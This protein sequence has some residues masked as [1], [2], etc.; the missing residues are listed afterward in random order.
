MIKKDIELRPHQKNAVDKIVQKN[1]NLL[2]S[3]ATGSGKTV[4]AL[5]GFEKLKEKGKAK[6]ALI[7]TPASLR[8]NFAKQGVEK[9]TTDKYVI[10]GNKIENASPDKRFIDPDKYDKKKNYHIVSYDMFKKD[11]EKYVEASGADTVIYDEIHRAKN[12]GTNVTKVIK[13]VRNQHRNFIG[14]TGSIVSN[15]PADIVPLVDAMTDGKHKLGS[16]ALFESRFL[17]IG[18]QGEKKIKNKKLIKILTAPYI[19]HVEISDLKIA[20][21]P[22]KISKEVSVPMSKHQENL[23][24]FMV[25]QLDPATK[26]KIR[27]GVGKKLKDREMAGIFSKLMATRKL[28]NYVQSANPEISHEESLIESPKMRRLLEDVEKHLKSTPDGQV[29]IGTQFIGAGVIPLKHHLE[30]MGYSP[31][32]FIGKGNKGVTESSRQ[33]AIE[34]FNAG[35]TKILIISGAGGEGINLPN[36]TKILML[37]GHYNPEVIQQMEARGIRAGG[38]SHRPEKD[39]KVEVTRYITHPS[40]RKIDVGLNLLDAI[41]PNTYIRRAFEGEPIMQNPFQRPYGSDELM[42]MVAKNKAESNMEL[43]ELFKKGAF[44][45]KDKG[46]LFYP[47]KIMEAYQKEF[48]HLLEID[49]PTDSEGWLDKEKEMKY[50][51]EYREIHANIAARSVMNKYLVGDKPNKTKG[52]KDKGTGYFYKVDDFD[53]VTGKLKTKKKIKKT[54]IDTS[55]LLPT[56]LMLFGLKNAGKNRFNDRYNDYL[57]PPTKGQKLLRAFK[58][59]AAPTVRAALFATALAT[60]L[61]YLTERRNVYHTVS[62]GKARKIKNL[63]D[64]ELRD[65][66]RGGV[67]TQEE[68]KLTQHY[69]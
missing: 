34:R 18:K 46:K 32:V 29:V 4:T 27:Y 44:T 16:K 22:K 63:S 54:A 17:N 28:S 5:A 49:A 36:T 42:T 31:D 8:D 21:P 30:K 14:L 11:P 53:P 52:K 50:V 19:D 13:D 47:K 65:I 12:E 38:Q 68:I 66:L 37:D 7:V 24:R 20:A 43:K 48:G 39:R 10:F 51:N 35:K 59:S 61:G 62:V 26:A 2:L 55:M 40:Y 57:K 58:R 15:T 3:H 25:D 67:V 6:K 23:Y 33:Q 1:G 69:G 45:N 60:G 56:S 9:F 41:S 64:E